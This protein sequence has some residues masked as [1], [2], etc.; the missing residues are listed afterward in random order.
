MRKSSRGFTILEILIVFALIA[1]LMAFV[2]PR[3]FDALSKTKSQE[4]K[5]RL[6]DLAQQIDYY[7]LDTGKYPSSLQDLVR[8]PS[9]MD[10][11]NGPY[12][13]N[14]E[15]LKDVWGNDYRYTVPGQNKAYDLTS[16][17]ADGRE[18]GDGENKDITNQ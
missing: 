13:K 4:A 18:G 10:K 7:R 17:G 12:V 14:P 6:M 9:G 16:L 1:G 8:Q 2:G 15:L 11:W 5:I 3:I